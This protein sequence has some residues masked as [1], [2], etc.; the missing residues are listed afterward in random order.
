MQFLSQLKEKTLESLAAV[1]PIT[2]IVFVL[3]VTIA[4]LETG[5][6]ILFLFGAV[7]LV[8][9]MGF[10]TL[11]VDMSM[12]PLGEGVGSVLSKK[13]RFIIPMIVFFVLGML[14][15]VAEPDLQ[16]LA[17]QV[18]A[19]GNQVLIW[20]VAVGVGFFLVVATFRIRKGIPLRRM[21]I[22]FYLIIF[23]LAFVAPNDFVPVSFDSGGVTTGPITV[24]FIMAL[25]IGIASSRSDK[26]SSSDSFGLVSLCSVGPILSVL[27]LSIVYKP[28][29]VDVS[30]SEIPSLSTSAQ[31][32]RYFLKAFPT[33]IEEVAI[34]IL[35]LVAVFV[36][37]QIFTRR[38][39]AN[40]LLRIILGFVYTY[41]GLVMFL[42]G[43]NVGFMPAGQTIGATIANSSHKWLLIPIGMLI[44][45]YIV[46]AEPAVAVLQKQVEEV[47]N[48]AI[49]HK[50]MGIALSVGVCVSVGLSMLRLLTGLNI[51]WL[52][53]PGYAIALGL[54]FFVPN[55]FTGIAFDSGGVASGPM[56]ATFLLPFA[57][58][59]CQ[60]IGG[61]MMTDAFGIVS[62]IAMTPLVTIQIMGLSS[63]VRHKLQIRKLHFHM[64]QVE[65]TVLFYD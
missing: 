60:A 9:G 52:L 30:L 59:A 34:A 47:S 26:N 43:V 7:L 63:I 4:P 14:A 5:T 37:F 31:A 62:M 50:A 55:I 16:V 18:S 23:A 58:G 13:K 12:T 32:A 1:L 64:E 44:G 21:L 29:S 56:T 40:E 6:L 28:D 33:Y 2:V 65:D 35:P 20:T 22:I 36:I 61:N 15:T 45:F 51:F 38:Y 39:S 17:N 48:G 53:I 54:S 25:G 3:S 24:P 49:S 8:G 11:G 42:C 27:L 57:Q 19:I 10:F 46:K 41:I